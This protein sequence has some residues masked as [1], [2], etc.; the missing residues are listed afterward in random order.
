M[1][2]S[3]TPESTEDQ[4]PHEVVAAIRRQS[5]PPLNVSQTVENAI[6]SDAAAH[7]S[8]IRR[9]NIKPPARQRF[10]WVAWSTGI[11]AAA[12]LLFAVLPQTIQEPASHPQSMALNDKSSAGEMEQ[13]FVSSD[14][15][16]DGQVDILDAFA[17]ARSVKSGSS[18][19]NR[20]DQNGDGSTDQTD[21][22]LIAMNAVML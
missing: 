18:Q 11:I 14:V 5:G 4:L 17:L 15:D 22:N 20:W 3:N 10:R 7:L 2:D 13:T 21:I 6:L 16:Q 9:P 1:N 19:A 12:V 8:G